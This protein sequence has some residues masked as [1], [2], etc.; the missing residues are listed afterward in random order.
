[1]KSRLDAPVAYGLTLT[2]SLFALFVAVATQEI[3]GMLPCAW[4]ITQRICL[5][6]VALL[7]VPGLFLSLAGKRS[8]MLA[9]AVVLANLLGASAALWQWAYASKS[10][11]CAQSFADKIL[12]WSELDLRIPMLFEP[13][14]TCSDATAPL[15]GL[16]YPLWSL[17]MFLFLL[18]L[19]ATATFPLSKKQ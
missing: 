16:P 1:M 3:L 13:R 14:A 17:A 15:L 19:M 4:C 18:G 12:L 7:S 2:L 8:A 5:V 6:A 11:T 9:V 10:D